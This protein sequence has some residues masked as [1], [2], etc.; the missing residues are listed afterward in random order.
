M[1]RS[2]IARTA[3]A[4]TAALLLL[5]GCVRLDTVDEYDEKAETSDMAPLTLDEAKAI[6][7]ETRTEIAAYLPEG[8]TSEVRAITESNTLIPCD[9]ENEYVWPGIYIA[10]IDGEVD[11][12]AVVDAIATEW[13]SRD[14]WVVERKTTEDGYDRALLTKPDGAHFAAGFH[15]DGTEFWVDSYSPCFILPGGFVGGELY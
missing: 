5:T 4:A 14:G 7:I 10:V 6:T 13:E 9:G 1:A 12:A 3:L 11:Q 2:G 15:V 8:V